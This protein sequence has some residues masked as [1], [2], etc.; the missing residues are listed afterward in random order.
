MAIRA[1][2][3]GAGCL[4]D[5][6]GAVKAVHPSGLSPKSAT[7]PRE[8]CLRF[9]F[10]T[11][12]EDGTW[13]VRSRAFG[14]QPYFESAFRTGWTSSSPRLRRR[15]PSLRWRLRCEHP[16]AFILA[17]HDGGDCSRGGVDVTSALC[18][19]RQRH[20]RG[21]DSRGSNRGSAAKM[22]TSN[23]GTC[24]AMR[25]SLRPHQSKRR[26]SSSL[27]FRPD[28]TTSPPRSKAFQP[29]TSR[30]VVGNRAPSSVRIT[31]PI[32]RIN[33][34]VTVGPERASRG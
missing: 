24:P 23:C 10:R 9:F 11:Q 32:A 14:F 21:Q 16:G 33:A 30:L 19:A 15:G 1:A 27:A 8:G 26:V 5:R 2:N 13:F 25:C 3:D 4:C 20:R 18:A 12:L 29:T 7:Y 34:E 31:M 28:D 22:P 17:D 6:R